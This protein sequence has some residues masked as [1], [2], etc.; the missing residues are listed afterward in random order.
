MY[1]GGMIVPILMTIVLVLIIFVLER[2]ITLGKCRVRPA[3]CF[4]AN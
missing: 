1:R 4:L 2:S 3:K